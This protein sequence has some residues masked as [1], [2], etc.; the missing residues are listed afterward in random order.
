[1]IGHKQVVNHIYPDPRYCIQP[2]VGF[3]YGTDIETARRTIIDTV[4]QVEGVLTD[5]PVDA[6]YPKWAIR[7]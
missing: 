1:L 7:P 3:G 4:R 6:L 2:H 5:K